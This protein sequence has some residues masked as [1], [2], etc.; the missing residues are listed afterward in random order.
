MFQL[1]TCTCTSGDLTCM[2]NYPQE[3]VPD[4]KTPQSAEGPPRDMFVAVRNML[5]IVSTKLQEDGWWIQGLNS[6]HK[7]CWGIVATCCNKIIPSITTDTFDWIH[8]YEYA[9]S[10]LG[11]IYVSYCN[12]KK[13]SESER[14]LADT[15][16]HDIASLHNDDVQ[17]YFEW[18]S[19]LQVVLHEWQRKICEN[20][21]NYDDLMNYASNQATLF[22]IGQSVCFRS[23]C[24]ESQDVRAP[25]RDLFGKLN[26]HFIKYIPESSD[27]KYCTLPQILN[28]YGILFPSKFTKHLLL[29][30]EKVSPSG[31]Q[32]LENRIILNPLGTFQ[33]P[34]LNVTLLAT[35]ALTMKELDLLV[36]Q[37][38][39]FVEPIVDHMC[40]L[41]FFSLNQ[42]EI[43]NNYILFQL[44]EARKD[45]VTF[46]I[47]KERE[48]GQKELE[49]LANVLNATRNFL[50]KLIQGTA[51]YSEIIAEG[52]ELKLESI[53][54][55][56]ELKTLNN[57]CA[58]RLVPEVNGQDGI[59]G[60]LVMVEL[61]QYTSI[62]IPSILDVCEQ[63]NL[64]GCLK[65][66]CLIDLAMLAK[67][68]EESRANLTSLVAVEKMHHVRT[69]LYFQNPEAHH[70]LSLF[71]AVAN[72][73]PFFQFIRD[74]KFDN[75]NG[76]AVFGQQFQLIT[77]Q[78]QHEEYN[79][80]VLNH[81]YAAYKF[82][83]PF[84]DTKQNFSSLMTKVTSL[85]V[86]G[87]LKQLETVNRNISHIRLWF[88]RAEVRAGC[89]V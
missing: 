67:A 48:D 40:M 81:L 56:T 57:F 1:C 32:L 3:I 44:E 38:D 12:G 5:T 8:S 4:L 88:S 27:A 61:L 34:G 37:L 6:Q 60:I 29:P 87:G 74:M 82:I 63:Y 65:D 11:Q 15:L 20:D 49:I 66:P 39:Q 72:S 16:P 28:R 31:E 22:R 86:S 46:V 19:R 59:Q 73:V 89:N 70:S 18:V 43:F 68:V 76:E 69:S 9:I 52:R 51:M 13:F 77:A 79:Q 55:E 42:S 84:M 41:V 47:N 36:H 45:V 33:P 2:Y 85:D 50:V 25:F 83:I 80:N 26:S 17:K 14:A 71:P 54:I 62:H 75:G 10:Q 64:E 7:L 35:K 21:C 78:L 30:G 24:N 58:M 53:N 23:A